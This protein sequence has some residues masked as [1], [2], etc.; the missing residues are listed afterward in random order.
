[1]FSGA[2][3]AEQTNLQTNPTQTNS[4][5]TELICGCSKCSKLAQSALESTR[6][7]GWLVTRKWNFTQNNS[8]LNGKCI[9]IYRALDDWVLGC[10]GRK[11]FP[12]SVV[13]PWQKKNSQIHCYLSLCGL[14]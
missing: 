14:E 9:S 13:I 4:E 12:L 11:Y 5:T 2:I 10:A 3:V 7:F 1:M 6:L 8:G